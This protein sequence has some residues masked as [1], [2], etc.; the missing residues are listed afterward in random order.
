MTSENLRCSAKLS[1][2]VAA[3]EDQL[4]LYSSIRASFLQRAAPEPTSPYAP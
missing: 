2:A 4:T 3:H 1:A